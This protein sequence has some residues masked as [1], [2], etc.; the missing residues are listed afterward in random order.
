MNDKKIWHQGH[1]HCQTIR[2]EAR[3]PKQPVATACNCSICKNIAFAIIPQEDFRLLSGSDNI[4]TYTFN[5]GAAKHTFCKTCGVKAFYSPRSHPSGV[6]VNMH[7]LDP[8]PEFSTEYFDGI[9]WEENIAKL[10]AKDNH[11]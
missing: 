4:T 1:C 8:I 5:T 7:C 10:H 11:D 6:S 9:H 3:M 2:F